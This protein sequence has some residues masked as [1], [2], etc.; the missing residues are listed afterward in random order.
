MD[1]HVRPRR[2]ARKPPGVPR[3]PAETQSVQLVVT[4]YWTKPV[5]GTFCKITDQLEARALGRQEVKGLQDRTQGE[6]W[7]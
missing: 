4:K 7:A 1:P 2:R 3:L 5:W 6:K